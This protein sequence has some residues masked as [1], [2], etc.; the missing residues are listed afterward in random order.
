[1]NTLRNLISRYLKS[2]NISRNKLAQLLGYSNISKALRNLDLFCNTLT[3]KNDISSKLQKV[4]NIPEPEYRKA[5]NQVSDKIKPTCVM[6][7]KPYIYAIEEPKIRRYPTEMRSIVHQRTVNIDFTVT[8][9]NY[10]EHLKALEALAM[11][12][13]NKSVGKIRNSKIVKYELRLGNCSR[14]I[15]LT[16][17]P[18]PFE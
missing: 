17:Q 5:I 2:N 10:I 16:F 11:E 14:P 18:E 1:M 6:Y 9:K 4:L 15:L 8:L 7:K 3:D 13:Y 12:H